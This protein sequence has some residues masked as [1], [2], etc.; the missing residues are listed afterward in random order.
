M[1]GETKICFDLTAF[2]DM[3]A[4]GEVGNVRAKSEHGHRD[5]ERDV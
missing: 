3:T 2:G 4:R 1:T 5:G